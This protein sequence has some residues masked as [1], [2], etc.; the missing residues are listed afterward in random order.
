MKNKK[1][2]EVSPM[3]LVIGAVILS[4]V[5]VWVVF[6]LFPELTQKL[7]PNIKGQREYVTEDCDEDGAT[8]AN[9]QCPCVEAKQKLEKRQSCG[10]SDKGKALKNCPNLCKI[11]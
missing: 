5:L 7:F 8:G 4:L 1:S 2:M 11:T 3:P 10:A 6:G 9:D